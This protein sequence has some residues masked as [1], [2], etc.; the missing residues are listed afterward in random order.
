MRV[1]F[2]TETDTSG[3]FYTKAFAQL[4]DGSW[5]R[6]KRNVYKQNDRFREARA[7]SFTIFSTPPPTYEA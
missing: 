1:L 3:T 5:L 2:Y 4:R 7:L 6:V